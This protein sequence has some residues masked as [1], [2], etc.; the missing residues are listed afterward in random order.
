MKKT[1]PII[2]L[3]CI[4]IVSVVLHVIYIYSIP[5]GCNNVE[6]TVGCARV[7]DIGAIKWTDGY[8]SDSIWDIEKTWELNK[9]AKLLRSLKL[10]ETLE[11]PTDV[12][13]VKISFTHSTYKGNEELKCVYV[14]YDFYKKRLY[15]NKNDKWYFMENNQEL[16]SVIIERMDGLG[17]KN[18]RGQSTYSWEE[19]PKADFENATFRYDLYWKKSNYPTVEENDLRLSGFNNTDE[20]PIDSRADAIKRA[21]EE[22][23][24]DNP[25]GVTFHDETCGYYMVELANDN[26]NGI[27]K[28]NDGVIELIE[29]IYTVIMDD[30]GRTLEVYK[31]FTRT[32]PFWP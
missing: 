12:Q 6:I 15:A 1:I 26:G 29:P 25:V 24:Y 2:S 16:N 21:A 4:I 20:V 22:L 18:W 11:L 23:D 14:A 3:V 8:A 31:G 27:V 28:I 10:V 7:N 9:F 30:K 19:F 32:R 13:L 17:G 5:H